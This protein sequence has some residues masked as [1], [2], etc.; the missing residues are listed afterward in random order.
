MSF[1]PSRPVLLQ[2]LFLLLFGVEC[3]FVLS[4]LLCGKQPPFFF[5]FPLVE[6][7][8][9][10]FLFALHFVAPFPFLFFLQ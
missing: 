2:I 6:F 3:V 1:F 5:F 4:P 8:V 9:V 10:D 7:P